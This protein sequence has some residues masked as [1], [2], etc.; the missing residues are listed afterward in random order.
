MILQF[1][2]NT[3]LLLERSEVGDLGACPYNIKDALFNSQVS[4]RS[5]TSS[6][7]NTFF[8]FWSGSHRYPYRPPQFSFVW[9]GA[10]SSSHTRMSWS[11]PNTVTAD[12]KHFG[13]LV[14]G[15]RGRRGSGGGKLCSSAT[16]MIAFS[17]LVTIF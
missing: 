7:A 5:T 1:I 8:T 16:M 2:E 4:I 10:Q 6:P 3:I 15:Q 11:E 13:T 12:P 9:S 14:S 17:T